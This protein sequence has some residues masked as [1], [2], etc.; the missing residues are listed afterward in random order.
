MGAAYTVLSGRENVGRVVVKEGKAIHRAFDVFGSL[1]CLLLS[2]PI[3]LVVALLVR[4]DG[5]PA[6]YR[7][8]RAGRNGEPFAAFKFRSMRVH[9]IPS[10]QLATLH[11]Q[12]TGGHPMVTP[13]GR[14]IRRFKID[15]L[16]QALNVLRGDMAL[17]GPRPTIPEQIVEYTDFQWR[18]LH[19]RPGMTG[20]AQI[21]GGIELT[22]QER[23]MLDV[24][25][26]EHRSVVLNL[27]IL[28][29]TISVI[30]FGEARDGSAWSTAE[31]YAKHLTGMAQLKWPQDRDEP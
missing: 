20:W 8:T 13:V 31:A 25:Y 29:R 7:Q 16:P 12:V 26:V 4:R 17:V 24:W 22:W 6:L 2:S 19:V 11:G 3:L 5:G 10:D 14:W 27:Q 21:H 28:Y 30:V 15:E 23:I 9:E 1:V 18:R